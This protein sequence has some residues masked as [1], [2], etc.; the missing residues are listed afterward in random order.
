MCHQLSKQ[1]LFVVFCLGLGLGLEAQADD[2]LAPGLAALERNQPK[3]AARS[4]RLLADQGV[5]EAQNALALLYQQGSGVPQDFAE[6][7]RLLESASAQQLSIATHNLGLAYYEGT[8]VEVDF[9]KAITLFLEA[10][11][12]DIAA[13]QYMLGVVFFLGQGT[14]VQIDESIRWLHLAARQ[15]YPEAQLML[16]QLYLTVASGKVRLL[17]AHVWG[18]IAHAN[19]MEQALDVTNYTQAALSTKQSAEAEAIID[20]CREDMSTC[21]S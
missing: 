4:W 14:E 16:A 1:L 9:G 3:T 7:I 19:G 2:R 18:T 5:P 20:E 8:G 17:D 12:A 6:A 13:A 10:A 15:N 21:N 11:E